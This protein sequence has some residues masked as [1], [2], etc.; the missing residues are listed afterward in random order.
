M[1]RPLAPCPHKQ[2]RGERVAR[3]CRRGD[4][5]RAVQYLAIANR[6]EIVHRFGRSA[7]ILGGWAW[8]FA[9]FGGLVFHGGGALSNCGRFAVART[10][11]TAKRLAC[12][13]PRPPAEQPARHVRWP[14]CP[15]LRYEQRVGLQAG[16]KL[17]CCR[18]QKNGE[19]KQGSLPAAEAPAAQERGL[20]APARSRFPLPV[21]V[22]SAAR[23]ARSTAAVGRGAA[24]G[25]ARAWITTRPERRY[26]RP[27]E[28][29]PPEEA[30][31]LS[32]LT[33]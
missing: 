9:C 3:V 11:R 10:E 27:S 32:P 12:W 19:A 15:S 14:T 16:D 24:A 6:R 1:R 5:R 26:L 4:G 23:A 17:L 7:A 22:R 25:Q 21:A 13:L 33:T 8:C 29:H 31:E 18:P 20:S 2:M 30:P 28:Q